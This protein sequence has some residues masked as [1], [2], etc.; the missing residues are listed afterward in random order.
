VKARWAWLR[1]TAWFALALASCDFAT[2]PIVDPLDPT[3][4]S[5]GDG[6]IAG[7]GGT[8]GQGGKSGAGGAGGAGKSGAGAGGAGTGGMGATCV[9][10]SFIEC[11]GAA[12]IR[13][14]ANGRD[15]QSQD[16]GVPGCNA[17]QRRCNACT[18]GETFCADPSTLATCGPDGL[19]SSD[20][21][22]DEG[23]NSAVSP[24]LC[25]HCAPGISFCFDGDTVRS[26]DGQ[27]NAQQDTDCPNGCTATSS[28]TAQCNACTPGEVLGCADALHQS[29]C[30][31]DGSGPESIDCDNGCSGDGVC[32]VCTPD[33]KTCSDANTLTTCNTEGT[34]TSDVQCAFGCNASE[35]NQCH[36]S[37]TECQSNKLVTCS[38]TGKTML[39]T[40]CPNGCDTTPTPDVCKPAP[41]PTLVPSNLYDSSVAPIPA[42][43]CET[44]TTQS[45]D[46]SVPED[47]TLMINTDGTC[48]RVKTQTGSL[49]AICVMVRRN[50]TF[51]A[52]S[53]VTVRGSRALALVATGTMS[54]KG[55]ID[56]S[57]VGQIGGPGAA[58]IGI[59]VGG[60]AKALPDMAEE[61]PGNA[62]G[63]G[64]GYGMGGGSGG[65]GPGTCNTAPCA[66]AVTGGYVQGLTSISP[67]RSGAR[68]GLNSA[69]PGTIRQGLPGGGGGALQFV[70]CTSMSIESTALIHVNGGGGQGGRS[71]TTATPGAGAGG[72]SGGAI[73]IEA[74][75]MTLAS[76]IQLFANGGG[77]GGGATLSMPGG[78]GDDGPRQRTTAAGGLAATGGSGSGISGPGGTG[79]AVNTGGNPLPAGAGGAVTDAANA[80]GGGGGGVGRIRLNNTSSSINGA[81]LIASP[82]PSVGMIAATCAATPIGP[83]LR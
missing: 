59:S 38:P 82:V 64:G 50:I 42:N 27:G 72:G 67:L 14:A 35:C 48:T 23:C 70:G 5:G 71:G 77:G 13:C 39:S 19:A 40:T 63:G 36:P 12:A 54:L 53:I 55:A 21:T 51:D 10:N 66:D 49:P 75:S 56:A 83:C 58:S 15:R 4:G 78:D 34:G 47:G 43:P 65:E 45:D 76:G 9:R 81:I 6:P 18:P 32:N 46:L 61:T 11:K 74:Q 52:G 8:A 44:V 20:E 57:A 28:S 68:G 16:C 33:T 3:S 22:C 60:T 7:D 25:N 69:K 62:G 24:A 2:A 17:V 73:L 37:T 1:H 41:T 26:C 29:R 80:A 79:G 31:S 30:K